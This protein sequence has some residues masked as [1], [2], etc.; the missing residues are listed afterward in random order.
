VTRVTTLQQDYLGKSAMLM[1]LLEEVAS[2]AAIALFI[3]MLAFWSNI[4][5]TLS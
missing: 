3:T 1:S 5:V 2:L 4:L